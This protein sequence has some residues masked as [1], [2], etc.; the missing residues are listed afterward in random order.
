MDVNQQLE[1]KEEVAV[2]QIEIHKE[3][4]KQNKEKQNKEKQQQAKKKDPPCSRC[5]KEKQVKKHHYPLGSRRMAFLCNHCYEV[6]K[7]QRKRAK[8]FGHS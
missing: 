5:K 6:V 3:Q 2:S 8:K 4:D 7:R 1:R